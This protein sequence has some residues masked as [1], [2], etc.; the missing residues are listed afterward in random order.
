MT[1]H[2]PRSWRLQ[3]WEEIP[4][5][6]GR[7]IHRRG[8]DDRIRGKHITESKKKQ[9]TIKQRKMAAA[10][11]GDKAQLSLQKIS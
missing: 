1:I 4:E 3:R 5:S 11:S 6:T 7:Q 8:G 10:D 2:G 9:K